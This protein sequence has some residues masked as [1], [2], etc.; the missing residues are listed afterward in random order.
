LRFS[1]GFRTIQED[2][3]KSIVF[4]ELIMQIKG[5]YCGLILALLV[6]AMVSAA[7]ADLS[8]YVATVGFDEEANLERGQGI[9]VRWGKSGKVLGGE[10]SVLIARPERQLEAGDEVSKET[11][12]ALFYEGRFLVNIPAGKVK[13]F[14]GVGFGAITITSTEPE[15]PAGAEEAVLQAFDAVSDLQTNTSISYGAGI[16][17]QLGDRLDFRAD[18]RQ[19][20][21]FSVKGL[22]AQQAQKQLEEK[23]GVDVPDLEEDST[24]QYNELS[25]GVSFRF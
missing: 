23:T 24:V 14:V 20:L 22:A 17:Y 15:V 19:Y 5:W 7:G 25:I 1:E 9:G 13:P 4:K 8:V 10:T 6:L 11:A 12:T 21:V 3:V 2:L 18:L 16:K